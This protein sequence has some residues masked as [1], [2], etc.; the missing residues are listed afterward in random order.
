MRQEE[1]EWCVKM[2]FDSERVFVPGKGM[3]QEPLRERY[4]AGGE[5]KDC[6][7]WS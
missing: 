6:R 1:E 3:S 5:T 4:E 7:I 2:D